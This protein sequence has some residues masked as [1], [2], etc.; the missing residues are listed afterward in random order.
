MQ[1]VFRD[2]WADR[3]NLDHLV[4]LRLRVVT[5]ERLI[6]TGARRGLQRDDRIDLFHGHQRPCLA[7]MPGLSSWTTPTGRPPTPLPLALRGIT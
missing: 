4:P 1:L 7:T 6:A 2:L 5:S 3:G